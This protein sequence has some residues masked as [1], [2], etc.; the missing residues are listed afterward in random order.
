MAFAVAPLPIAA[1]DAPLNAPLEPIQLPLDRLDLP[2][3][4]R[5]FRIMQGQL[6]AVGRKSLD[7]AYD[8]GLVL[9]AVRE[10]AGKGK[11]LGWCEAEGLEAR[12]AQ[13]YIKFRVTV[14]ERDKLSHLP[15]DTSVRG[16]MALLAEKKLPGPATPPRIFPVATPKDVH[17]EELDARDLPEY[18]VAHCQQLGL[19][20]LIVTSWPYGLKKDEHG[21]R[22]YDDYERWLADVPRWLNQYLRILKPNGRV[23]VVLPLDTRLGRTPRPMAAHAVQVFEGTGYVYQTAIVWSKAAD[24]QTSR[25]SAL[26]SVESPN[27]PCITTGDELILVFH[28]GE[29]NLGRT[30]EANDQQDDA[31]AAKWRNAHWVIGGRTDSAYPCVFPPEIPKRLIKLLTYPGAV[32]ADLHCG[33]GTV[34]VEAMKLGRRFVGGDVNPFAVALSSQRVATAYAEMSKGQSHGG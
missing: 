27:A 26:G 17:L 22:D 32:V 19:V 6:E 15:S 7:V 16:A 23:C 9:E 12:T 8:L 20:D 2:G 25:A 18:F 30:G 10:K 14:G 33:S 3:L 1:E 13:R 29:W 4:T 31:E 28:L 34:A 11:W 24:G 21:Y 5:R